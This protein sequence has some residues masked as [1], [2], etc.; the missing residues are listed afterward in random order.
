MLGR[1]S[2][3][4]CL[5][6]F[7]KCLPLLIP[8]CFETEWD[9]F[10]QKKKIPF[11][12]SVA[13]YRLYLALFCLWYHTFEATSTTRVRIP[14]NPVPRN[15]TRSPPV[16]YPPTILSI[17]SLFR[18]QV[19]ACPL[20]RTFMVEVKATSDAITPDHRR[21][22]MK[23]VWFW[24]FHERLHTS[25]VRSRFFGCPWL[26]GTRQSWRCRVQPSY[27]IFSSVAAVASN[28]KPE[29]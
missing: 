25:Y 23:M 15:L 8:L 12:P 6:F 22:S 18:V 11:W 24:P 1:R 19:R 21:L 9:K 16:G 10:W 5:L 29:N 4:H 7:Y 27:V 17:I 28:M 20:S 13:K 26:K 2:C 3:Q 14:Q